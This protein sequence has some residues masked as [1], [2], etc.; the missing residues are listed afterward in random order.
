ML[1]YRRLPLP[2]WRFQVATPSFCMRR[3]LPENAISSTKV[4]KQLGRGMVALSRLRVVHR[5]MAMSKDVVTGANYQKAGSDPPLRPDSEYPE[6]LWDIM[7][8][9]EPLFALQRKLGP[10][11]DIKTLSLKEVRAATAV[12]LRLVL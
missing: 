11:R 12:I 2:G 8:P 6:W 1:Y 10:E 5:G 7:K 4:P 3:A 9:K